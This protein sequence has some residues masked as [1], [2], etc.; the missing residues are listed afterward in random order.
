VLPVTGKTANNQWYQVVL[1]GKPGWVSA[2]LTLP[3]AAA[4]AVAVVNAAAPSPAASTAV[5]ST[6]TT[7]ATT[8]TTTTV[9]AATTVPTT[10]TVPATTTV[11][12]AG[13]VAPT[14][15]GPAVVINAR[16][17]MNLRAEPN[18]TA[19]VVGNAKRGVVLPVTAK[20]AEG[21]WYQVDFNGTPAWALASL[22]VPNAAAESAPI[23]P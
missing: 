14:G 4:K 15:D 7:T 8:T 5:T 20:N 13:V 12:S 16:V 3:N 19:R 6:Q 17:S 9:P 2:N 23:A 18:P 11:P 1:N 21:T 10:S 22:T